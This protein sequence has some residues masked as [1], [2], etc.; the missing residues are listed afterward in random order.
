MQA[1]LGFA[2]VFQWWIMAGWINGGAHS[3]FLCK[4]NADDGDTNASI[5]IATFALSSNEIS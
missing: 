1:E 4:R 3:S 2:C 5:D